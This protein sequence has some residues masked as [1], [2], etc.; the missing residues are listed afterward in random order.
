MYTN[1]IT[2]GRIARRTGFREIRYAPIFHYIKGEENTL[3]NAL[4]RLL[5][6]ERQS[7]DSQ[8]TKT[9]NDRYQSIVLD[10][11]K[12]Q[13]ANDSNQTSLQNPITFY[14]M[15]IDDPDLIDCFAL[16]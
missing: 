13:N 6:T 10:S 4:S 7:T 16:R 2:G 1:S 15:A 5:I 14:S 3:A 11:V 12:D 8:R 9:L